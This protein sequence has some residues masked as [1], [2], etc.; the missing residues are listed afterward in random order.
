MEHFLDIYFYLKTNA[1]S[2][3]KK[4]IEET[5]G[6]T[7]GHNTPRRRLLPFL[8]D[9]V[10]VLQIY[11]H[12]GCNYI[13][14]T[15]SVEDAYVFEENFSRTKRE[16][17]ALVETAFHTIPDILFAAVND[18]GAYFIK[19]QHKNIWEDFDHALLHGFALLYISRQ[20]VATLPESPL[21]TGL[22]D[23]CCNGYDNKIGDVI[24][25]YNPKAKLPLLVD[26][27]P[28][29]SKLTIRAG[30]MRKIFSPGEILRIF[31][32][33]GWKIQI[34]GYINYLSS[35]DEDGTVRWRETKSIDEFFTTLREKEKDET[36]GIELWWKRT[37]TNGLLY[38]RPN[39][40]HEHYAEANISFRFLLN[41][42]IKRFAFRH[43]GEWVNPAEFVDV[44]WYLERTV[45]CLKKQMSIFEF[46]FED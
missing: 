38:L 42:Q 10:V 9:R 2:D 17:L 18:E 25:V 11:E 39:L 16:I 3:L 12:E 27:P 46:S 31:L 14:L 35:H 29:V 45:L 8:S 4:Q 19:D 36:I 40:I 23:F 1:L 26:A 20:I 22:L 34:D 43:E 21:R 37:K 6:L 13:E 32:E 15:L 44:N 7:I 28:A 5:F 24:C 30:M 41:R 33:Y